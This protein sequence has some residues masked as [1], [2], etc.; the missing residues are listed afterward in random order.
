[1]KKRWNKEEGRR[2][3][4]VMVWALIFRAKKN[5]DIKA[6]KRKTEDWQE[7]DNFSWQR[8]EHAGMIFDR[9]LSRSHWTEEGGERT[10][11]AIVRAVPGTIVAPYVASSSVA[12]PCWADATKL[13]LFSVGLFS[14]CYALMGLQLFGGDSAIDRSIYGTLHVTKDAW[15]LL[16][17]ILAL[18]LEVCHELF[19]LVLNSFWFIVSVVVL[20]IVAGALGWDKERGSSLD[21]RGR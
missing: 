19:V 7:K 6:K 9:V 12:G 17:D 11:L 18:N 5:Y 20:H 3:G 4:G 10:G 21:L 1:M 14:M 16:L 13:F 2:G 8:Q 15:T